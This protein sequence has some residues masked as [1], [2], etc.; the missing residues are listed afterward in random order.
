M[1]INTMILHLLAGVACGREHTCYHNG[2]PKIIHEVEQDAHWHADSL[3]N[4]NS[5]R[6]KVEA[7]PCPFCWN[8]HV[9]RAMDMDTL[10]YLAAKVGREQFIAATT[11]S[12][13]EV[14]T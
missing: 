13:Q 7:Y 14:A 12:R 5:G 10:K 3:N 8:W 1:E 2:R 9:G 6:R 4:H 11:G